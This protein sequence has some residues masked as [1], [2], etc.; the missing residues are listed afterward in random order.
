MRV[1]V[2]KYTVQVIAME[3]S[4]AC[5]VGLRAAGLCGVFHQLHHLEDLAEEVAVV[6]AV[7][8]R[9][10]EEPETTEEEKR[11]LGG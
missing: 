5:L 9:L 4:H 6:A 3:Q 10:Q 2:C 11:G 1:R 8:N 7:D